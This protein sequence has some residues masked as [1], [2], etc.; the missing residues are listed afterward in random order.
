MERKAFRPASSMMSEYHPIDSRFSDIP[1]LPDLD[2]RTSEY[3]YFLESDTPFKLIKIGR[4][5]SLKRRLMGLQASCPVQLRLIAAI[6]GPAGTETLFHWA[7]SKA[8]AHGE[9]FLPTVEVVGL[10]K[11]LP[12][13]GALSHEETRAICEA[14]G[15]TPLQ[16]TRAFMLADK[17][18]RRRPRMRYGRL[19]FA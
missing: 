3:V 10:A 19:V 15:C 9:W 8:R 6:R 4:T 5:E 18:T 7:F 14:R 16:V 1:S 13:L 2:L 11:Q 17:S 12:K